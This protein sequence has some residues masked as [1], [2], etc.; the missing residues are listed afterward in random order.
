M[1]NKIINYISDDVWDFNRPSLNRF[2]LHLG[3]NHAE[4]TF[5]PY[6]SNGWVLEDKTILTSLISL[7]HVIVGELGL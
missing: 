3:P 1:T 7:C 6:L 4:L 5:V 2:M